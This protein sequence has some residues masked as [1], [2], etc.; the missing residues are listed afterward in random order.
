MT[1]QTQKDAVLALI[2]TVVAKITA[3]VPDPDVNPLQAPLDAANVQIA[4]LQ[5]AN[6]RLQTKINNAMLDLG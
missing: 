6:T 3:F 1:T 4:A 5:V 2:D